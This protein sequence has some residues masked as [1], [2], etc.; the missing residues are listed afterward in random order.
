MAEDVRPLGAAYENTRGRIAELVGGSADGADAVDVPACPGWSVKDVIAH[1]TGNG[2]D[3]FQGNLAGFATS[4]WTAAQVEARRELELGDILKEWDE[5]GPK[6][7]AVLD[8]FPGRY[9][10][11]VVADLV[12]HEHDLRGALEKPGDRNSETVRLATDFAMSVIVGT[13]AQ[14]FG[15]G[16]LEVRAGED[17]WVVGTGEARPGDQESWRETVAADALPP[18]PEADPVGTLTAETFQLFRAITGRRSASQIRRFEWSVDP[19]QF[20]PLFGYG[21]FVIRDTDLE[22]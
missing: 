18:P 14:V 5:V 12:I 19:E 13:G 22:E 4:E 8:D 6:F 16:P 3:V 10:E 11:Q 7:A 20:L 17:R 15:F 1:L 2:A 9:G 21:P